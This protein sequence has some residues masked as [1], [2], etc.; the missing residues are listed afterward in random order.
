[1]HQLAIGLIL[2]SL[3]M[4]V[5]RIWLHTRWHYKLL[6]VGAYAGDLV[7]LLALWFRW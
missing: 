4:D 5:L 7:I 1:M 6:A 3:A 2:L